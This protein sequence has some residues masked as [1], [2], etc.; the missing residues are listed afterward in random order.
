M[1]DSPTQAEELHYILEKNGYQAVIAHNGREALD[2]LATKKPILVIS[3]IV[4]PEMDG[5]EL[6]RRIKG[7]DA[8]KEIP[9]I[10][11][12][13]L[14]DPEDVLRGLECGADNFI[15]KPYDESYLIA[16]VHHMLINTELRKG[17]K[18]Q[19]GVEIFFKEQKYFITSERQQILDLLLST[20]ETAVM[21][22]HELKTVQEKLEV[23]NEQ[24]EEKV[25]ERTAE[26]RESEARYRCLLESV[27]DYIYTVDVANEQ[28]VASSHGPGCRTV[29]GYAPE[30]FSD[31]PMLWYR[32]IHEEDR[33][34][35]L[36]QAKMLLSGS[37]LPREHR[38]I[39]KDGGIRWVRNTPVLRR[40]LQGQ[41]YSYDGL[42]SD[43]TE[44]KR[45]EE[46]LRAS[47]K[48]YRRVSQEFNALLDNLPDGIVHIAPDL[49]VIWANRSLTELVE[50]V[51]DE[52][53]GNYCYESFCKFREPCDPCPV[54]RSFLSNKFE[55]GN[56]S[57][58]DGRFFELRV[59]PISDESGKVESV[60]EVI[61]DITEHRKLEEQLR[62]AQKMESIGTLAGGIAHDFN[63]ILTAI[64]GFGHLALMQMGPDDPLRE[65]IEH[66]LEGGDRAA[67]LTKDLL[68]FSRKEI[69]E[70]RPVDLNDIISKVEKFLVRVIGE[71][72]KCS[73]A[74]HSEPIVVHADPHQLEQV[75]MNLAANA[76]DAMTE[77]GDL[78]IGTE[79][80]SFDDDFVAIHG[81]GK[82]GRYALMTI[83]D[84]GEGM[85]EETRQKMFDPFFTTKEVGK[86]TGLGLAVV[87]GIIKQHEGFINVYSE[88]GSGTSFRI[89]LPL[90]P[91]ESCGEE[92]PGVEEILARGTETILF[93]EDDE[94][95]RN[96][97]G[98]VLK[99]EGYTV[100]EAV[101]GIDAVKKF[102]ENREAIHLFVSDLIMPK[103]DGKAAYDEMKALR[104]R[105]E[106]NICE[107]IRSRSYPAEDGP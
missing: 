90:I 75:L 29:T 37:A 5:F 96:L 16:R 13:A 63:N 11:L 97:I 49:R 53:R 33:P 104:A 44:R 70:K 14:S 67:Q 65:D 17:S 69:S 52:L 102:I 62:Q 77:G 42:I 58:P 78:I 39:H 88:P 28:P 99:Q 60:I 18:L 41:I 94:S 56:I 50:A 51:G 6:C 59:M 47:E 10:L 20:Y 43:I 89:Y 55:E 79:L 2:M 54:S 24:L 92:T 83:S 101:D 7:N 74:L 35:V 73:I 61:R 86:G 84:T 45:S 68:I 40:D 46:K 82:V 23:L 103:M 48:K 8:L 1:E 71:D 80:I 9:V 64:I 106:G 26:L 57:T 15:I 22:N 3:D 87:Y 4:M 36:E 100:I 38:I 81:Y 93:A 91:T 21:K 12:T 25:S 85:D 76:R 107:R 98:I 72:I 34:I 19:I 27:T 30:E 66:M 32:M 105:T 95:V 31:D